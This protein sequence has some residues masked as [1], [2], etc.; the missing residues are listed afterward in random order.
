LS[1]ETESSDASSEEFIE[2]KDEFL[3]KQLQLAVVKGLDINSERKVYITSL[4]RDN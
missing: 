3:A 1:E 4:I 2:K